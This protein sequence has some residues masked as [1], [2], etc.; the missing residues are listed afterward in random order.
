MSSRSHVTGGS[1]FIKYRADN[2]PA[3]A[4]NQ[5]HGVLNTRCRLGS[6]TRSTRIPTDTITNASRVPMDT[7][8]AASRIGR[9]AAKKA[10]M[11]PVTIEVMYGVWNLGCTLLTNGGRSPSPDIEENTRDWPRSITTIPDDNPA[12]A[13][14]LNT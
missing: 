11:T 2:A 12:I 7:R 9:I 5:T 14:G 3:G 10:T 1:D 13:P 6:R 8:L 4:T